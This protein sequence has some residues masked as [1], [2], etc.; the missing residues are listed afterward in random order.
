M[1]SINFVSINNLIFYTMDDLHNRAPQD[2]K[3]ISLS[4]DWEVK[5]WTKSLGVSAQQLAEVVAEAGNS[6]EKVK[7]YLKS[8]SDRHS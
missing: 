2:G 4:E 5:W 3:F 8:S 7:E 6:A 1:G